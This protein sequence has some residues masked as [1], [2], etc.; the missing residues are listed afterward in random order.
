MPI[1]DGRIRTPRV[2]RVAARIS[3]MQRVTHDTLELTVAVLP[4]EAP[5]YPQAG[6]FLTLKVPG[7]ERPRPYSLA[8]APA[9]QAD[10]EYSF[11]IRLLPDGEL[12]S[13]LA[14]TDRTGARVE[15][16]GPLGRFRLDQ[17]TGPI[18]CIA[19]GSGMS[20][21]FA[22]LEDACRRQI[23]RDCHFYYGAREARDLYWQTAIDAI[24]AGWHGES[25]FTYTPVLS[26]EPRSSDWRGHRGWVSDVA[27][28]DGNRRDWPAVSVFLC[29]PPQMIDRAVPALT[30]A[31][32]EPHRCYHDR[33]EDARSPAP[34]IDNQRCVLCDECL[35][36]K[37]VAGCI[38]ETAHLDRNGS[39]AAV[40]YRP[41]V[42]TQTPALYYNALMV[43]P[44]AC[45]RCGACMDAC[46]HGAI[47]RSPGVAAVTLRQ[48]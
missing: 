13:W 47:S 1:P 42:P 12:S 4:G 44:A 10:G 27:V 40:G 32:V 33:F 23:R 11:L 38:V 34:V 15:L 43:D 37:P 5:L 8:R 31:G 41:H 3:R 24:G 18:V 39:G 9:A 46:P 26:D 30:A 29:G 35:L 21:S 7:V 6:Q 36:V 17:A 19:G 22:L 16:G 28:A 45:I 14:A 20:A 2:R 25:S 48:R